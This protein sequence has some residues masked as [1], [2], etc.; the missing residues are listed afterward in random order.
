MRRPGRR[1]A[2]PGL[3]RAAVRVAHATVRA[4]T[5]AVA[6]PTVWAAHATDPACTWLGSRR[7]FVGAERWP[8]VQSPIADY[9]APRPELL[10]DDSRGLLAAVGHSMGGWILTLTAARAADPPRAITS[11]MDD[12]VPCRSS[13]VAWSAAR[14]WRDHSQ[15]QPWRRGARGLPPCRGRSPSRGIP[16]GCPG[17]DG[18]ET[19]APPRSAPALEPH[20]AH[21]DVSPRLAP[22]RPSH[23]SQTIAWAPCL[24]GT[25]R[26]L[27]PRS[28]RS[29]H[30]PRP[31]HG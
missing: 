10:A 27:T 8:G 28:T 13:T 22:P 14:P 16:A 17:L 5:V 11:N 18:L 6:H 30:D 4:A 7:S 3:A 24:A 25:T 23:G 1:R 21:P 29:E 9:R 20:H 15:P 12:S 26:T 2:V 19:H 31:T